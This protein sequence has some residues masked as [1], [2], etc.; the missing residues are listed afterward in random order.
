MSL[1]LSIYNT[2]PVSFAFL[3][4]L[5]LCASLQYIILKFLCLSIYEIFFWASLVAQW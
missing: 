4:Q 3:L 5:Q 2:Y 1:S